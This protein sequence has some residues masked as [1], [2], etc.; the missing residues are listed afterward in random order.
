MKPLIVIPAYNEAETLPEVLKDLKD[1][2]KAD[3]LV[4]DDGSI[5]D[6]MNTCLK[7]GVRVI[8]HEINVG[9][10]GAIRTGLETAK[11]ERY[12]YMVTFDAD[13]QHD[14][15]D[16]GKMIE[17]L[18][19]GGDVA[20]GV[21]RIERENMPLIKKIGNS[22]LNTATWVFFGVKSRDSQSG[23]RAF[24][25]KAINTLKIRSLRYEVSSEILYEVKSAGLELREVDVKTIYT[26]RSLKQATGVKDGVKILWRIILHKGGFK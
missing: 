24:N 9:L 26:N 11:R 15:K 18:R 19:D 6:T 12:E 3:I 8:R 22:I 2:V 10:G 7:N 21:R 16:V 5:D 17:A 14:P 25:R 20:I 23:L 4:V 13:G 1:C